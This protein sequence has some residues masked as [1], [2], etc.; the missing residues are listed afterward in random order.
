MN[1]HLAKYILAR[2]L[3]TKAIVD[4][5]KSSQPGAEKYYTI[6]LGLMSLYFHDI[7]NSFFSMIF[8]RKDLCLQKFE[9]RIF[10]AAKLQELKVSSIELKEI[11]FD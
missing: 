3:F 2:A 1:K 4:R 10:S 11:D 7:R 8:R 6:K 9:I 5:F